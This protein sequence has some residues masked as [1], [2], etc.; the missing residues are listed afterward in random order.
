MPEE[1]TEKEREV[2]ELNAIGLPK[3]E[4][5]KRLNIT[6]ATIQAHLNNIAAKYGM[7][8]KMNMQY[9][10]ACEYIKELTQKLNSEISH[11]AEEINH[12]CEENSKLIKL[13]EELRQ[14]SKDERKT[15][16]I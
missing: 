9:F 13:A 12:L 14:A 7:P 6:R 11:A 15:E 4:I 8:D 1:L 10:L 5:C 16:C 2:F 3:L